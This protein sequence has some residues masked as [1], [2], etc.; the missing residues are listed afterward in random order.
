[1]SEHYPKK[2]IETTSWCNKC[3]R[4]T[5][6][7]VMGGRVLHCLEHLVQQRTRAQ[8]KRDKKRRDPQMDLFA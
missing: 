3:N 6:H 5:Q 1:M 4:M 2:T 8:E 7:R